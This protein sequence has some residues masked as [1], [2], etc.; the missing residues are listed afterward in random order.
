MTRHAQAISLEVDGV[1]PDEAFSV[2]LPSERTDDRLIDPAELDDDA[3][4]T[5]S[6]AQG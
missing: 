6:R 4:E 5:L 1:I 2:H 3:L